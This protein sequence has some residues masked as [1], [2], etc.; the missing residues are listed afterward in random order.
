VTSADVAG[1]DTGDMFAAIDAGNADKF[2]GF[3]SNDAVFRFGSAPPVQGRDAIHA[4]V[5][6]FFKSIA[7]CT[8]TIHKTIR[9]DNTLVCEGDVT[10]R[11]MDNSE[12]SLPF[13]D[14]L[15]FDGEL[16]SHYKIY[17]DV[18]PLYAA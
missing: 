1:R 13:T 16:I 14:V 12:I 8:H 3:L 9:E 15:E 10:Y 18:G 17:L 7:G 11:R 4:A 2:V 6:G 5:S